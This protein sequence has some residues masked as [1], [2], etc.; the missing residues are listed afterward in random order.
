MEN[1]IG[2]SMDS[3]MREIFPFRIGALATCSVQEREKSTKITCLDKG[4]VLAAT[5]TQEQEGQTSLGRITTFV[6]E[7]VMDVWPTASI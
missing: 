6:C 7:K 4:D 3:C 5:D 1:E 2:Y